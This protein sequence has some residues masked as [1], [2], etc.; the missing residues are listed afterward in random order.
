MCILGNIRKTSYVS[1]ITDMSLCINRLDNLIS[2]VE[3]KDSAIL[4]KPL[5]W[6]FLNAHHHVLN[7]GGVFFRACHVV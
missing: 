1:P 5:L 3:F 2:N 6:G 4:G 7:A